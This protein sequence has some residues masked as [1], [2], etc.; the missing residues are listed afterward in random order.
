[1][2]YIGHCPEHFDK[3]LYFM[4]HGELCWPE[5]PPGTIANHSCPKIPHL[6]FD[7][8]RLAYKECWE[9]GTWFRNKENR[10][11]SNYTQCVNK[12]EFEVREYTNQY[13]LT[14]EIIFL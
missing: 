1:M 7:P 9:N 14:E 13:L 10:E 5:T 8:S 4:L 6:G 3:L 12:E 11:W 2:A